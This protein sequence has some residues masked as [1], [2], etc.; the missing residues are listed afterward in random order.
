VCLGHCASFGAA[1][2]GLDAGDLENRRRVLQIGVKPVRVDLLTSLL[3]RQFESAWTKRE[4]V[5]WQGAK[6]HLIS[7]ADLLKATLKCGQPW[8]WLDLLQLLN[9]LVN[10]RPAAPE[11][12]RAGERRRQ[13]MRTAKLFRSGGSQ[14]VRLRPGFDLQVPKC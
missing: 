9:T 12:L 5:I 13:P 2:A 10:D 4:T 3:G 7:R 14:A 8:A 1:L 11:I 6:M